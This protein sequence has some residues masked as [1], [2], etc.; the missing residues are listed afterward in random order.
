MST[1]KVRIKLELDAELAIVVAAIAHHEQHSLEER[2]REALLELCDRVRDGVTRPGSWERPWLVQG[3]GPGFIDRLEG[4][5]VLPW[6]Q[7]VRGAPEG[8]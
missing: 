2:V 3:L 1:R 7:R 5:P 6:K 8:A 4:D